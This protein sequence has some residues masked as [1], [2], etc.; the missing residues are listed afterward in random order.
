MAHAPTLA[1]P[2][3]WS[4]DL[5]MRSDEKIVSDLASTLKSKRDKAAAELRAWIDTSGGDGFWKRLRHLAALASKQEFVRALPTVAELVLPPLA[6]GTPW[7]EAKREYAALIAAFGE[8]ET[9]L[10]STGSNIANVAEPARRELEKRVRGDVALAVRLAKLLHTRPYL[11]AGARRGPYALFPTLVRNGQWDARHESLIRITYDYGTPSDGAILRE[12]I[13]AVPE[14]RRKA[15]FD[16][17]VHSGDLAIVGKH[18]LDLYPPVLARVLEARRI[19]VKDRRVKALA[20]KDP[21][22]RAILAAYKPPKRVIPKKPEK[23]PFDIVDPKVV[24][25]ADYKRLGSVD[26]AQ[27]ALNASG[28]AGTRVRNPRE[29]LAAL[30]KEEL[31]ASD[32]EM[33]RWRVLRDGKHIYDLWIAWVDGGTL[34]HAGTKREVG[35]RLIQGHFDAR[36][37]LEALADELERSEPEGSWWRKGPR[38]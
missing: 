33:R 37:R 3:Q 16:R 32:M 23:G 11:M 21:R 5:G 18:L 6:F 34:F 12:I 26:K 31:D 4:D 15:I 8:A 30:E 29:F 13:S 17:A 14:H 28:F 1:A 2:W 38:G 27:W 24:Q 22:V 19:G 25:P 7:Q 9:L 35:V 20:E 10:M 36:G